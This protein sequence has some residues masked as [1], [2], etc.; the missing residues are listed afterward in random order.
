MK[1][2]MGRT[3]AGR[4]I[5]WLGVVAA[6]LLAWP[7]TGRAQ[8]GLPE[9][10]GK[11]LTATVCTQCH[12]LDNIMNMRLGREEWSGLVNDM[13]SRGAPA[14]DNQHEIIIDYLAAN[15]GKDSP[16]PAIGAGAGQRSA[17][18]TG[19]AEGA[20]KELVES[21]C[22]RCHDLS[23]VTESR[24]TAEEWK[25]VVNDMI[26]R[27]ALLSDDE[28][29]VVVPYL[30]ENYG[31]GGGTPMAS[32]AAPQGRRGA[33]AGSGGPAGLPDGPGKELVATVCTQCHGLN[34]IVNMRL[35]AQDWE[36]LVNDMISR[37]A[38][39]FDDQYKAIAQYLSTHFGNGK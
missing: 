33:E 5:A 32:A 25:N 39:A 4:G 38:P 34:N 12:G 9:G 17:R 16:P 22:A 6:L 35:S 11:E 23:F 27:G 18:G 29:A 1:P 3:S 14:F 20:G 37:G 8:A 7:E 24:Y 21:N 30:A 36:S 28:T 26:S 31:P 15:F 19:V 10:A 13:I 2:R